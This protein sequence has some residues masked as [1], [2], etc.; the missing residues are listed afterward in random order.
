MGAIVTRQKIDWREIRKDLVLR[1]R[2][3]REGARDVTEGLKDFAG[4]S[5]E[6]A[7]ERYDE[8]RVELREWWQTPRSIEQRVDDVRAFQ[9]QARVDSVK[10]ARQLSETGYDK[11]RFVAA[12]VR[13]QGL[14][15]KRAQRM[16]YAPMMLAFHEAKA[17]EVLSLLSAKRRAQLVPAAEAIRDAQLKMLE[18]TSR[19]HDCGLCERYY[20][21]ETGGQ[22][23][24]GYV[25][26]WF[27]PLDGVFRRLLG[28]RAPVWPRLHRD[29]SRCGY[30][31]ERGCLLPA[32]TRPIICVGFYCDDFRE[33]LTVD[34]VWRE[35][36]QEF[37]ALRAAIRQL[38]FR[39]NMHRRFLAESGPT[40]N[41]GS[42]GYLWNKI[43]GL[44]AA[45]DQITPSEQPAGI[46]A[47]DG[48]KIGGAEEPPAE[49]TSS[50][51]GTVLASY[52]AEAAAEA[53]AA[54]ENDRAL[55]EPAGP[56]EE[57]S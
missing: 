17:G 16:A 41:D 9:R 36:G 14:M 56:A 4:E 23:C 24:S 39:F 15:G 37:E 48:E 51:M 20:E 35:M 22:C 3:F 26:Q 10:R 47:I 12:H 28:E 5:A 55:E 43:M 34:G 44:Y 31:G 49:E 42:V 45:F 18:R 13:L 21:N 19:Y 1:Y 38:D 8:A 40:I 52:I 25:G 46:N 57:P 11:T 6:E 2:L 53:E 32:G 29:W 54:E 33:R 27:R 30:M 7:K 50:G